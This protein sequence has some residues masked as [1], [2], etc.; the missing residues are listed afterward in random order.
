MS[1]G[2]AFLAILAAHIEFPLDSKNRGKI[3][4]GVTSLIITSV[5]I[6]I[7]STNEVSKFE[8]FHSEN[9]KSSHV[10]IGQL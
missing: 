7:F 4:V 8:I 10:L 1:H 6:G 3:G 5:Y 2:L 9:F